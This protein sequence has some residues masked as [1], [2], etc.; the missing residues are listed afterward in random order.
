MRKIIIF[1]ASYGGGH[2]SVSNALSAYFKSNYPKMSVEII[3]FMERFVAGDRIMRALYKQSA[4]RLPAAYGLFFKLTDKLFDKQIWKNKLAPSVDKVRKFL[5]AYKPDTVISV[6]PIPGI[7]AAMLGPEL[8]FKSATV[9]TDFG[10]HSQ[11][12]YDKTDIYFVP[13]ENLKQFLVTKGIKTSRI[14]VTGI[15]IKSTFSS[16]TRPELIRKQLGLRRRF[17]ALLMSGEYGFGSIRKLCQRLLKLDLQLIVICGKNKK[18]F[19][20]INELK[21]KAKADNLVCFGFTDRVHELMAA[22]DVL[23]GKAGGISVSEALAVGLPLV[24]YRPIPGQE[25]YNVDY[26]VNEGAALFGRDKDDVTAKV[27]Y[28][29]THPKRLA[30][31]KKHA[32]QIGKPK[33]TQ[34]I[35]R[36]IAALK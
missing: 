20:R 35:C 23:I 16:R 36:M 33:S 7:V 29:S 27:D 32:R 1:T 9:I 12:I 30:E 17:T 24:V 34:T 14:K 31:M 13:T 3:D 5:A 22:S 26:L 25:V 19:R 11:W 18:L 2:N 4:K 10:A 8:G 15:P 21:Y 6:Y 28:L